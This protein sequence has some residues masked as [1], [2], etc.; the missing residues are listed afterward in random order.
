MFVFRRLFDVAS[1]TDTCLLVESD[2]SE[3]LLIDAVC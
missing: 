3:A 1:S 2:S